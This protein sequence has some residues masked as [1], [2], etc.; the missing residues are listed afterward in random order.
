ME[1]NSKVFQ[2]TRN[3]W[4]VQNYVSERLF[5]THCLYTT[6]IVDIHQVSLMSQA[7]SKK[8][9]PQ[10]SVPKMVYYH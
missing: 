6:T 2:E 10:F 4:E 9:D 7:I 3:T 8:I 5:L 1:V